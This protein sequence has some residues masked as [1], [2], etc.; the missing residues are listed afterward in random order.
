MS[1]PLVIEGGIIIALVLMIVAT[2]IQLPEQGANQISY[3]KSEETALILPPSVS[4]TRAIKRQPPVPTVPVNIPNDEP[5]D[6]PHIEIIEFNTT[7]RL[8]VPPL[9][10]QIFVDVNHDLLKDIE[11]LPVMIGGEDAFRQSIEYPVMA[12][13]MRIQGIVE[14]EFDVDEHG[15][16]HN[17]VIVRGI[18]GGCDKAVLK[19]IKI[20]RYKPGKKAGRIASFRIKETVQFI[21]LDV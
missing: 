4:E 19:A 21:L 16:V 9:P 8:M 17:P 3:V 2:K 1:Y 7:D 5:I 14:V 10:G 13:R 6:P 11:Q 20:Q 12:R 15:R 18:G